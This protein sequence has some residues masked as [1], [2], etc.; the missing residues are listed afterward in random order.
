MH[1]K[2]DLRVRIEI[3]TSGSCAVNTAA[4]DFGTCLRMRR[5]T[6]YSIFELMLMT[7]VCAVFTLANLAPEAGDT[8]FTPFNT[9]YFLQ[10]ISRGWPIAYQ[11]EF[12]EKKF[13]GQ[14]TEPERKELRAEFSNRT[15]LKITSSFGLCVNLL[16]LLAVL[17]S[18][19][20]AVI[21][22]SSLRTF[23]IGEKETLFTPPIS[24]DSKSINKSRKPGEFGVGKLIPRLGC[25]GR[26]RR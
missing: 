7:P 1:A 15:H 13:H 12:S 23:E 5:L 6:S 24:L 19:H 16:V 25:R 17:A 3:W 10:Y 9:G 11:A 20:V 8:E 2:P 22:I 26:Y 4:K 21:V 18:A 14:L